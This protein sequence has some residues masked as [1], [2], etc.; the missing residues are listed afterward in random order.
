VTLQANNVSNYLSDI[1][2]S[3]R[4]EKVLLLKCISV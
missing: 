2:W 4:L 3:Y 1:T